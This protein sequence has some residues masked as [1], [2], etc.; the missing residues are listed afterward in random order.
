VIIDKRRENLY[1]VACL[2]LFEGVHPNGVTDNVGNHPNAFFNSSVQ[3]FKD[4]EKN[5][6]K[7]STSA[8][9]EAGA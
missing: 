9:N 1:Q 4:V 5:K 2:R 6:A 7:R 3:Y 8:A